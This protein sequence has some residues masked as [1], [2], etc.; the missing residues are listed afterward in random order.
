MAKFTKKPVTI[1]AV[2]WVCTNVQEIKDFAGDAAK[3]EKKVSYIGSGISTEQTFLVIHTLEGNMHADFNDYI[4]KGVQ[5]EFYPCKPDIFK[6][7]YTAATD[8]A[9]GMTFGAAIEALKHGK[10]VARRGWNGKGMYLWLMQPATVKAEW[11]KEP[12]L[13]ALAEKNG[14]TIEALGSIRMLTAD[15]KILTGWNASQAD[16]LSEDWI[17]VN[18]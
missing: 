16:I 7:T 14:G 9:E 10:F 5:G 17:I 3:F 4:I 13:K 11:C 15:G 2:Q 1:E 18:P 8:D 12:H 6:K